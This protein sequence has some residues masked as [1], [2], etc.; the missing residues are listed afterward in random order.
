VDHPFG[1]IPSVE[2]PAPYL[3]PQEEVM[4]LAVRRALRGLHAVPERVQR[5][6]QKKG[7]EGSDSPL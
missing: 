6:T 3:M 2:A 4:R 7:L 5:F 1:D